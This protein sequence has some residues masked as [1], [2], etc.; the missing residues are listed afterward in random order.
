MPASQPSPY[1]PRILGGI[2]LVAWILLLK[3]FPV[4]TFMAMCVACVSYPLYQ[5]LCE[6]FSGFRGTAIYILSLS[7]LT[8]LPI[9]VVVMLITPQA[10]AGLRVLDELRAAG[11][12][13]SPDAQAFVNSINE[14]II[15]I[16]GMEGGLNQILDSLA[17][18]AG[19]LTRTV[20]AGGVGLAG[21]AFQGVLVLL[22][23][24]MLAVLGVTQAQTIRELSLRLSGFPTPVFNR[25]LTTIRKA[26]YGVMVGVV[27][28][29][30]IQGILCSIG[31]A[32]AEVPQAA[33]WGLLATFVA[34]IPFVGTALV[35]LPVSGWLWFAGSKTMAI[36]LILWCSLVVAGV[37]NFLRPFFLK[38][39]IDATVVALILA[40]LCGLSSFGPV[41]IFAGPVLVAVAIQ[42]SRESTASDAEL[43]NG[44]NTNIL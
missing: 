13:L 28:V 1:L 29:A 10:A 26:I 11:W 2:G 25:F 9:V 19:E 12:V 7:L 36:A 31:F 27:F 35:W 38:T 24:V 43:I 3:P 37:D 5:R 17:Q 6:R 15:K 14:F 39:G 22:I 44:K 30:M 32:Y 21:S 34:P 4:T 42:A 18:A 23:F 41:G 8:M 33:F 20:L 16:P 40:I